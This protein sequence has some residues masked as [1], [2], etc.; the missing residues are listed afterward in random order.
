MARGGYAP[1]SAAA[2]AAGG[3]ER[4][5]FAAA[6]LV[7]LAVAAAAA[8][9]YHR[10]YSET[11]APP[12][13][14]DEGTAWVTLIK[15]PGAGGIIA[16]PYGKSRNMIY[17]DGRPIGI[18]TKP[19]D[20][21]L[22]RDDGG[23]RFVRVG[24]WLA[25]STLDGSDPN[26]N[27]RQYR[28]HIYWGQRFWVQ[29]L[30]AS[31]AILVLAFL[32]ALYWRG[33]LQR[34]VAAGVVGGVAAL[35]LGIVDNALLWLLL[36]AVTASAAY[37][38]ALAGGLLFHADRQPRFDRLA[39]NL[40]LSV[41]AVGCCLIGAEI[42]LWVL[43]PAAPRQAASLF[44]LLVPPA[45]AEIVAAPVMPD[46]ATGLVP[47]EVLDNAAARYKLLA[48][49]QAWARRPVDIAGDYRA[50]YWHQVLHVYNID[51]MRYPGPI[52]K[53]PD[54]MFRI[55]VLGDSLTYG[56]GI[57]ERYTYVRQLERLLRA[58]YRV[59]IVNAGI[60]GA[61]SEDIVRIARRMIPRTRPDLVVYGVCENDF[62]PSFMPQYDGSIHLPRLIAEKTRL[63][64]YVQNAV[65][66]LL[67]RLG[68]A[69]DFFDD[70]LAGAHNYQ[71]RFAADVSELEALVIGSGLPPVIALVLD[72]GPS[73][74][75]RGQQIAAI[76]ERAL[77]N[78][79]MTV[80]ATSDYYHVYN[81]HMMGVSRFEGHPNEEAN[82]I[83]ATMLA[84]VIA[85]DPRLKSFAIEPKS[86]Q[87]ASAP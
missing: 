63:G 41:G 49:P 2:A 24:N 17:E 1:P 15:D 69:R 87:A 85:R 80:I 11:L 53:K 60:E 20:L 30:L 22:V 31:A 59:D 57:E 70:I 4:L 76:A 71:A 48:L 61:Q 86:A 56:T 55:L 42:L 84:P 28:F 38:V 50:L 6:L 83:W 46:A 40:A 18:T 16:P 39:E 43:S 26:S 52:P 73:E 13:A 75:G 44:D 9:L 36:T 32:V 67:I 62:L 5:L 10:T 14:H 3:R 8:V 74:G 23:G 81:G 35:H 25:F 29:A 66:E 64:S 45:K 33:R 77:D 65:S 51:S 19:A 78:A 37:L 21:A 7:F 82:A 54:G 27:G 34:A 79:G 12:F 47:K 72:Q 68:L 58:R